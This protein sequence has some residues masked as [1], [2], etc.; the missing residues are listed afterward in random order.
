MSL[1]EGQK[2]KLII[3]KNIVKKITEPKSTNTRATSD[4]KLGEGRPLVVK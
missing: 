4:R 1:F 2:E 3:K